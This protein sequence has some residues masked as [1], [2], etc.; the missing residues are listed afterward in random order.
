VSVDNTRTQVF[1]S[2]SHKDQEYLDQLQ[3]HLKPLIRDKRVDIWDDTM[4]QTGS[5]WREEIRDAIS[6]AKAAV[7]LVSPS[8]FASD[9]IAESELPPI[10]EA[11]ASDGMTVMSVIVRPSR[12]ERDQLSQFQAINHVS[13][14]LSD[15]PT[16]KRDVVFEK[17]SQTLERL[18]TSAQPSPATV[19]PQDSKS[20][21]TPPKETPANPPAAAAIPKRK[22]A[23][24]AGR[25]SG[26]ARPRSVPRMIAPPRVFVSAPVDSVLDARQLAIKR[27]VLAALDKAGF[28]PQEFG[29]SGLPAQMAWN[30]EA[31]R[32]VMGNCQ[33]AFI[34]GFARW[35]VSTD[36]G[37][38]TM[39]TEYNHFEGGLATSLELPIF[40]MAEAGV[41]QRGIVYPGGGKLIVT[42]PESADERWLESDSFT[43]HFQSWRAAVNTHAN[44]FLASTSALRSTAAK[45]KLYLSSIGVTVR[46]LQDFQL[47]ASAR[48]EVERVVGSCATAIFLFGG[49]GDEP[50]RDNLL[51]ELGYFARAK[52]F[53]KILVILEKGASLP[54]DMAGIIYSSL[55]DPA[56]IGPIETH[57]RAFVHAKL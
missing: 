2:Y 16:G 4:I 51:F 10:L 19:R 42:I 27:G 49:G 39:L 17:L 36:A 52:G 33:G 18:L 41:Q 50:G 35:R 13:Q 1:I 22:S 21:P 38:M 48:D 25:D 30:F 44:V 23:R 57:L 6:R 28:E 31:A 45:V 12:Y 11:A 56:D 55:G 24:F 5:R 3:D 9:F 37:L 32:E 53:Q 34:F 26:A 7:L 15:M 20:P 40:L 46:D 43:A 8:F 14:P 47:G 54:S 29:A